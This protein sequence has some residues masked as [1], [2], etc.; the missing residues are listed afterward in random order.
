MSTVHVSEK[1]TR[2]SITISKDLKNRAEEQSSKENRSLANL[3][4]VAL[5][6]YLNNHK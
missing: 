5:A 6:E 4:N 2:I 1:N 3:I